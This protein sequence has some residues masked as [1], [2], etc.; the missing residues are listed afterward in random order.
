MNQE[1][2]FIEQVYINR[3]F[4]LF[5][6]PDTQVLR[7]RLRYPQ[8]ISM[9]SAAKGSTIPEFILDA[10]NVE[11]IVNLIENFFLLEQP[12]SV[13]PRWVSR[14][15][16]DVNQEEIIQQMKQLED[17]LNTNPVK[18]HIDLNRLKELQQE[19]LMDPQQP[20]S[21]P[22]NNF[23]FRNRNNYCL[24]CTLRDRFLNFHQSKFSAMEQEPES[25]AMVENDRFYKE[26][27]YEMTDYASRIIGSEELLADTEYKGKKVV[28]SMVSEDLLYSLASFALMLTKGNV[29]IVGTCSGKRFFVYED[30]ANDIATEEDEGL[31]F[32]NNFFVLH[33]TEDPF[34]GKTIVAIKN[35]Q[36]ALFIFASP[37]DYPELYD[38]EIMELFSS[39]IYDYVVNGVKQEFYDDF[40]KKLFSFLK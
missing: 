4:A 25:C 21:M 31:N 9:S 3:K 12:S 2:G 16:M 35:S 13:C 8:T 34:E 22:K 15:N 32:Q 39:I 37:K 10:T 5:R 20:W 30:V 24:Y 6:N 26:R 19:L 29:H 33:T 36:G 17:Q 28:F 1:V 14:I 23:T 40:Y 18:N 38:S 11:D 27:T 7:R